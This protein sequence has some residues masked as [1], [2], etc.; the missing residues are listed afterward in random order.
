M[1]ACTLQQWD[2]AMRWLN[3][4][5]QSVR[6]KLYGVSLRW[7][8]AKKIVQ[9]VSD[10]YLEIAREEI[11]YIRSICKKKNAK[12]DFGQEMDGMDYIDRAF[13]RL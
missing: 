11:V 10:V 9:C 4:N 1:N 8:W 12:S 6:G 5:I 2:E 3:N 13:L 7:E